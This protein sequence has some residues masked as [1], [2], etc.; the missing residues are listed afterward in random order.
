MPIL[1]KTGF[2]KFHAVPKK[3]ITKHFQDTKDIQRNVISI[4]NNISA[5]D[6]KK[7]F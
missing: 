2:F 5:T 3:K 7:C 1:L 6:F 4:L